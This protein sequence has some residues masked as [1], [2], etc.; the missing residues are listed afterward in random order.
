MKKNLLGLGLSLLA[1]L[2]LIAQTPRMSLFEEFTGENCPPCASTNPGLNAILLSPLN[3]TKVIPLK[4]QVPIPSAP[5]NTWSLYKTNQVE[6]DWRYKS[7][8]LGGYGYF[9]Q[10]TSGTAPTSGINAAPTGFFDGQHQ[11]VFGAASDHPAYVTNAVIS[12]AQS[13]TSA[14]SIS[15]LHDW[16]IGQSAVVVTVNITASANFNSVGPLIFR[17]VMV[18]RLIQFA[19]AP[20][21]NGEKIFEDVVIKSY[22]SLQGGTSMATGWITGQTQSFVLTCAV[23]SYIRDIKQISMVGFIQDDGNRTVAQAT[24]SQANNDAVAVSTKLDPVCTSTAAPLITVS[25]SGASSISNM[26]IAS[27]VDGIAGGTTTWAGN[28]ASG[29]STTILLNSITSPAG[30]GAHTFSYNITAMNGV[31]F[32]MA[33]NG[34]K[35]SFV[36]GTGASGNTIA[37]GF[38]STVFPPAAWTSVNVNGGITWSR[39]TVAG[40][41]FQTPYQSGKYDFYSNT[42]IGDV[43]ELY[44]PPTD[45][46]GGNSVIMTFDYAYAQRDLSSNDR[47]EVLVSSDCG[48]TWTSV[49]DK[50][51]AAL[52][53]APPAGGL[54][55]VPDP[56]DFAQWQTAMLSLPGFNQASV[57]CKFRVTNDNGN[58]LYIDNVNLV[59][60]S[61]SGITGHPTSGISAEIY[62]NPSNGVATIELNGVVSGSTKITILNALGQRVYSSERTLTEG[63]NILPLDLQT[64]P[65]GLYHIT[66]ENKGLTCTKKLTLIR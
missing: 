55:Y 6:I 54:V 62:P 10:W 40:G 26:T 49:F 50:A 64:F 65:S 17:C 44:L 29:A 46:R 43:D 56:T 22:P 52:K 20:G 57:L 16:N 27:Y 41:Y 12:A 25:N 28:L 24:R 47:L 18:E 13:Y 3:A 33:N 60:S 39:S 14:F 51:G 36:V 58:N 48:A 9:S 2:N 23:P 61:P 45:L 21:T 63:D 38:T 30:A 32:N 66:L 42:V 19:T 7:T 4:W 34:N 35:V 31:D 11:W 15:M 59:Q 8:S 53:T 1:G 37:E 5:T